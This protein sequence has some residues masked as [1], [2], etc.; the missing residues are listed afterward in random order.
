MEAHRSLPREDPVELGPDL[1]ELLPDGRATFGHMAIVA[2]RALVLTLVLLASSCG[3]GGGGVRLVSPPDWMNRYCLKAARSLGYAVLC[4]TKVPQ[5]PDMTPCRG[6]APKNELW[7]PRDCHQYVL[8]GLFTGPSSYRGPFGNSVGHLALWTVRKGSD[9]DTSGLFGCPGGGIRRGDATVAAFK[10]TW[11]FCPHRSANLQSGHI[12]FQWLRHGL[13]YG[14]SVHRN[15][16]TNRRLVE[17]L[18]QSV[19]LVGRGSP[20]SS[21]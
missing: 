19:R 7:D 12:A 5:R 14:V 15:T 11:W 3:G 10:G 9:F 18:V 1:V 21:E 13:K 8:D 16:A 6:R 2:R 17:S 20:G 4:P